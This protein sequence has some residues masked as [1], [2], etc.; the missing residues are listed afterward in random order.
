[1][2]FGCQLSGLT[3]ANRVCSYVDEDLFLALCN[4]RVSREENSVSALRGRKQPGVGTVASLDQ[5]RIDL[6]FSAFVFQSKIPE[7]DN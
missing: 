5:C 6:Q 3:P 2:N 7:E 4:N 1:V